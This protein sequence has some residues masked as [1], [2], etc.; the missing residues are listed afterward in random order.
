MLVQILQ[1]HVGIV[2]LTPAGGILHANEHFLSMFGYT[3]PHLRKMRHEALYASDCAVSVDYEKLWNKIL[4]NDRTVHV[5]LC[6]RD[7]GSSFWLR[8]TYHLLRNAN[9]KAEL[10]VGLCDDVSE[11]M[12]ETQANAM[13]LA[14]VDCTLLAAS[15]SPSGDCLSANE[16]CLNT[17]GLT[18]QELAGRNILD[19]FGSLLTPEEHEKIKSCLRMG[20]SYSLRLRWPRFDGAVVQ[21]DVWLLPLR[22]DGKE[23]H[24]IMLLA[25]DM[26]ARLGYDR[27]KMVR[28]RHLAEAVDRSRN[29]I[30]ITDGGFKALY[31]NAAFSDI[32]GY[33][34]KIMVGTSPT[35]VFGANEKRI[36]DEIRT[37]LSSA[38]SLRL[39]EAAYGK[40]GQK[41][42]F[43]LWVSTFTDQ[44]D[45]NKRIILTFTDI[46]NTKLCEVLQHTALEAMAHELSVLELFPLLR[47]EVENFIPGLH[48]VGLK[49]DD[50]GE[51]RG[52][53][54]SRA[55]RDVEALH[56]VISLTDTPIY[57]ALKRRSTVTVQDI[58]KSSYPQ[59]VK[60]AYAA[61]RIGA[62]L[63]QPV[64]SGKN[65]LF[66]MVVFLYN[67]VTEQNNFHLRVAGVIAEICAIAVKW[68]ETR[69]ALLMFT[70]YNSV[71][72]LPNLN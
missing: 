30:V 46:T 25:A 55:E 57:D 32:F 22:K 40:F 12:A 27:K 33:A 9:G 23:I 35:S 67:T 72:G 34:R 41:M 61:L 49:M 52:I 63:V 13:Q 20:G 37:G 16:N 8:A 45:H 21:L 6:Q 5:A 7:N 19:I 39:E 3:L 11:L 1:Q 42:W 38:T 28:Y 43:S 4:G 15:I 53:S 31:A 17:L 68:S 58:S 36:L 14:S 62:V 26:T 24:K 10:V 60:D 64:Y 66:G 70:H 65:E 71:T 69:K 29:A 51:L 18:W 47:R 44:Y 59:Y 56:R 2:E 54:Y 50:H 48:V